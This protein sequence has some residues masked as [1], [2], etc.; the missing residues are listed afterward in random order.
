MLVD[1]HC[2]LNFPDFKDDLEAVVMRAEK[3]GVGKM[4]SICTRSEEFAEINSIAEKYDNVF[5]TIGVHPHEAEKEP[6]IT[7]A[8]IVEFT[9]NPKCVGIGETGLDF[10]YEHS[11][12]EI[13]QNVFVEHI[14]AAKQTGLPAIIH[15][16]SADAETIQTIKENCGF[17]GLIHCF[18]TSYDVAKAAMDAG[19]YISISGIITFKKADELRAAVKKIPL[20]S[21]LVETDSPY[22]AP[23]PH[24]GKRNEPAFAKCTAEFLA[25]LKGV[26]FNRLAEITTANFYRLF[27]K[28]T[29]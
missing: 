13:Q 9:K 5:C 10:F 28:V 29:R 3:N 11:P 22:L 8:E 12:R 16:R 24:R 4:V 6:N 19:L 27:S 1:S 25:E 21:L 7:M 23:L 26:S 15:S 17:P 20:E 18:S 2:H 14:K